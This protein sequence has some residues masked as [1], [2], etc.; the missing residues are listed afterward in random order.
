MKKIVFLYFC[1]SLTILACKSDDDGLHET[2]G[3]SEDLTDIPNNPQPYIL[4]TS[5]YIPDME[6]PADNPEF[7]NPFK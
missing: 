2:G 3:N 4:T 1:V 6:V 7:Q 5:S